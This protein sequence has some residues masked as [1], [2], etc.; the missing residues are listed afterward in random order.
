MLKT[1]KIFWLKV[2][3]KGKKF[4]NYKNKKTKDNEQYF[5]GIFE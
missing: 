4:V 5:D 1:M 2:Q 3:Q